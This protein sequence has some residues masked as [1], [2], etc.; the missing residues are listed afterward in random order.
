MVAVDPFRVLGGDIV[1]LF[2]SVRRHFD[3]KMSLVFNIP[4]NLPKV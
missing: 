2:V 3:N 1:G 4:Y